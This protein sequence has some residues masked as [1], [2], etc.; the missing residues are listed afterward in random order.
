MLQI[1]ELLDG[2]Y[3]ILNEIGHGGMSVVYLALNERANKTWAVKEVR[4]NGANNNEVVTQ[5]LVAETELLKKLSHP[6]LPSIVDVIDKND[7]FIIVMD[8]IQGTSLQDRIDTYGAQDPKDVI[9]WARQLCDVLGYLHSRTPAI[10]YRD[11]KP[12]NVMLKPDGNVVLIDFGTARETKIGNDKD[13]TWLGTRGYAAPEQFGGRGQTD[14]R[15]D[16]YTLGATMY[17]LVTGFSPAD[18]MFQ[19]YPVSKYRPELAGSGLEQIILKC[20]QAERA[21]RFQSCAELAYALDNPDLYDTG[22]KKRRKRRWISFLASSAVT[23]AG[24]IGMIG[25]TAAKNATISQSFDTYL[26]RAEASADL[27][28]GKDYYE[29]AMS[30]QPDN[31]E[32]YEAVYD[33]IVED[34]VFSNEEKQLLDACCKSYPLTGGNYT[35][36]ESFSRRNPEGYARFRYN[37]G[38]GYFFYYPNG[39]S[40]AAQELADLQNTTALSDNQKK[41]ANSLYTIANYYSEISANKGTWLNEGNSWQDVWGIFTDLIGNADEAIGKCGNTETAIALYREMMTQISTRT[42]DFVSAGILQTE[43][44]Q[45]LDTARAFMRSYASSD[46]GKNDA[47]KELIRQTNDAIEAASRAVSSAYRSAALAG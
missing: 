23:L 20:C 21:D 40:Y 17:H 10:I 3:K 9:K 44:E 31:E 14:A 16:I 35:N 39:Y 8:Y 33:T 12:A 22:E 18:T 4:K 1:G 2:K 43:M 28:D 6:H 27:A 38:Y 11:M 19:I 15:T 46:E 36:L 34:G 24:V 29:S 5:G 25:F 7:S 42:Q 13:T 26:N 37:L 41:I 32:V 30:L 45:M 47:T